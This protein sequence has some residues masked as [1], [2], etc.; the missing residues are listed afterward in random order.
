M[1]YNTAVK[2]MK[3]TDFL[4]FVRSNS[5]EL[6]REDGVI[7]GDPAADV[8]GILVCFLA[9]LDA[10][11]TARREG[12]SLVVTHETPFLPMA[13]ISKVPEDWR[14]WSVN[15]ARIKEIEDGGL[16]VVRLHSSL[17]RWLIYDTFREMLGLPADGEGQGYGKVYSAD[18]ATLR[19]WIE[20]AK[21]A[22]GLD[23]I[24]FIGDPERVVSRVGLPFG[25]LSLFV[26]IGCVERMVRAGA[27]L[28]IGGESDDHAL[29]YMADAGVAFIELGHSPTENPGLIRFSEV[30]REQFPGLKVVYY[31]SRPRYCW[32]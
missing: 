1:C 18:P 14:E 26:N 25:G 5:G 15:K 9:T 10:L 29:L 11:Q 22:A 30:L 19:T 28:L 12:C 24:R 31:D 4:D 6:G 2:A 13:G 17:D 21:A 27:D 20:K 23:C 7:G 8:K 16:T 32:A 3:V